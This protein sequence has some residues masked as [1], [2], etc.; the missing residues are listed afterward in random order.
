MSFKNN[1]HCTGKIIIKLIDQNQFSTFKDYIQTIQYFQ[2]YK[3]L[4]CIFCIG[5]NKLVSQL[6]ITPSLITIK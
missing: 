2:T 3:F 4:N 6:S 5:T 1:T